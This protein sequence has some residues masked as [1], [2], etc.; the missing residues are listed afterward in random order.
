MTDILD[1]RFLLRLARDTVTD[2]KGGAEEV[3]R[4]APGRDAV[5]L[6][7]ALTVVASLMIG[8]VVGLFIAQPEV[9]PLTG[10][11]TLALGMIQAVFLVVIV[12][13][14][15]HVGRMFGG[16]SDFD[17]ALA[18][19]TWLQF[20]F[21]LVQVVQFFA[22]VLVPPIAALIAILAIGLFFWLLV[23][24]I[25]VLHGFTS[26]GMVFVMTLLSFVSILF[27]L[28]LVLA[29]LGIATDLNTDGPFR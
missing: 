2:P 17:G 21:L 1:L 23:N 10:R 28:S 25:T 14:I 22:M 27:A 20:V 26:L 18:L 8:E 11:S 7:F 9:G 19:M 24:F 16:V 29:L 15:T 4:L 12:F 6:A 3:L 5:W 13:A